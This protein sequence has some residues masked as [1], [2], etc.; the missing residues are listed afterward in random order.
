MALVL[1]GPALVPRRALPCAGPSI[2]IYDEDFD[3]LSSRSFAHSG[4][5]CF[6]RTRHLWQDPSSHPKPG[7][8]ALC[9]LWPHCL[10]LSWEEWLW[11]GGA[12]V[13]S[14]GLASSSDWPLTVPGP[15][16]PGLPSLR[17]AA[18]DM[19]LFESS[20]TFFALLLG[21][22]LAMEVLTWLIIYFL[23]PGWVPSTL[24]ALLL[25]TSQ[26]TR[27]LSCSSLNCATDAGPGTCRQPGHA[28]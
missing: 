16:G 14:R 26:V 23:G 21:Q 15:A 8:L 12:S 6:S 4:F 9:L 11:G 3:E 17:Q 28:C 5:L 7:D 19:K 25:A 18:Q 20:P 1:A 10:G 22:I 27:A 24:T 13:D 2:P